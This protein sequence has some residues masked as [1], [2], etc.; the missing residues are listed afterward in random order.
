[1]AILARMGE[2]AAEERALKHLRRCVPQTCESMPETTLREIVARGHALANRY[3]FRDEFDFF[4]YLNLMFV[5]G[6]DFD[7]DARYPWAARSLNRQDMTGRPK[8]DAL[9]DRALL[10]CS[11]AD[12]ERTP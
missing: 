5:L 4:R 10:F 8:M 12:R 6:F 1:M 9:M 7:T 3:G 11:T 2:R